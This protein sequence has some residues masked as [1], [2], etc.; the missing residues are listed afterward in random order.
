MGKTA[1][2]LNIAQHAVLKEHMATAT[3]AL[4]MSKEQLDNRLFA[5]QAPMD[6]RCSEDGILASDW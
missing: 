4:E 5:L 3:S 2:V 6:A 1:F